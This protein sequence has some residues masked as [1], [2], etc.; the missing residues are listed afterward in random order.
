M[1]DSGQAL[2]AGRATAGGGVRAEGDRGAAEGRTLDERA[3]GAAVRPLERRPGRRR[4]ATTATRTAPAIRPA[5]AGRRRAARGGQQYGR[6]N[7]RGTRPWDAYGRADRR[8]DDRRDPLGRPLKEGTSGSD[9]SGDV[10]VPEKMEEARTRAIQEELRRRDGDRSR[11]Q[12]EL[13]YI[14]R[15]LRQF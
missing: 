7:G 8:A 1:R 13:D 5:V 3:D 9:E 14:E 6:D 10:Q 11:P 4:T 2:G 15:L 12:P